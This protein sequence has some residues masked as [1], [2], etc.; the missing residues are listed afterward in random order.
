MKKKSRLFNLLPNTVTN[1]MYSI[2]PSHNIQQ[3]AD[4]KIYCNRAAMN[5]QVTYW[6][7][8]TSDNCTAILIAAHTS[9]LVALSIPAI[10]TMRPKASAMHK[11]R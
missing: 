3:K 7:L 4:I 5:L 6:H 9:L 1:N 11:F 8:N 10:N 2:T